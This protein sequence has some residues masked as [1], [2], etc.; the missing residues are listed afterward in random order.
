MKNLKTRSHCGRRKREEHGNRT[1]YEG[2]KTKIKML[3]DSSCFSTPVSTF[4]VFCW[5]PS[6]ASRSFSRRTSK[7]SLVLSFRWRNRW[8]AT[9]RVMV[10]PSREAKAT[11]LRSKFVKLASSDGQVSATLLCAIKYR[12]WMNYESVFDEMVLQ[13]S[14]CLRGSRVR[15]K[16]LD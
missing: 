16:H 15:G 8:L 7:A 9:G 3:T 2:I 10:A 12:V 13:C 1:H 4:G 11:T 5:S 6:A 14:L